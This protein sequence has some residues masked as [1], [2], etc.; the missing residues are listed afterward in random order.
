MFRLGEHIQAKLVEAVEENRWII[1]YQGQL[2]QV[3]NN[4]GLKFQPNHT[5]RLV[6]TQLHPLELKI[7]SSAPQG[8]SPY[9]QRRV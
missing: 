4:S 5:I 1:S 2:F 3:Q 6:V 9:Y 8:K 7:V